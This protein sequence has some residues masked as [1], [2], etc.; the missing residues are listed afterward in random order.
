MFEFQTLRD[1]I[2]FAI[3]LEKVSH[4]FYIQLADDVTDAGVRQYLLEIAKQEQIHEDQLQSLLDSA[5][6]DLEEAVDAGEIKSY[7]DAMQV[8]DDL[9]YKKAVK[10]AY[11]KEKAS[12]LLYTILSNTAGPDYIKRLLLLLAKQEKRHR[13]FFAREYKRICISEN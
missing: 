9:D 7:V 8:P 12:Q 2:R 1:V 4:N 11:D 10:I 3:S 5:E 6:G 13:E